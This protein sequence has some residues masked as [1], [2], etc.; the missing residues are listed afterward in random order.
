M[1]PETI[2]VTY[3]ISCL[4]RHYTFYLLCSYSSGIDKILAVVAWP[5]IMLNGGRGMLSL[6]V[7][8]YSVTMSSLLY[9]AAYP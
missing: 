7:A 6:G 8:T 2:S 9:W 4:A 5:G 3:C 1:L